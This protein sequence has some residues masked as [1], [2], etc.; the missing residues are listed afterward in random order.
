M[1]RLDGGDRGQADASALGQKFLRRSGIGAAR[2]RIAN[3]GREEFEETI[4][5]RSRRQR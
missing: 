5:A 3:V 4:E 2:V 1:H